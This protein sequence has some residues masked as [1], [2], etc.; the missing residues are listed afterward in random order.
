MTPRDALA[1]ALGSA[2][3]GEVVVRS[4]DVVGHIHVQKGVIVW[5]DLSSVPA[6]MEDV[7]RHVGVE[8]DADV[9]AATREE[10][11]TSRVHFM[12]VLVAW[13]IIHADRAKEAVRAFVSKRVEM[14]LALP[15]AAA[16]FLPKARPHAEPVR[17]SAGDTPLA[18]SPVRSRTPF[19]SSPTTTP[20]PLP[21]AEVSGLFEEAAR[22]EGA[23][24]VAVL[25][26]RTGKSILLSGAELNTAVAWSQV[27]L[28]AEPRAARAGGDR[29]DG[30]AL[31]HRPPDSGGPLARALRRPPASG[32]DR[33]PGALDDRP[34][35]VHGGSLPGP[36]M[37]VS[38]SI[39]RNEQEHG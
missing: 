25:D 4:G 37:T 5:A 23:V 24:S 35:C 19:P 13:K 1:E 2:A 33:R 17:F 15:D 14:A 27:S 7:V 39:E 31:L 16:L 10:C 20:R 11:R 6:S 22:L 26:C 12:D 32:D 34:D 18:R 8:L 30:R 36:R 9:I 38:G 3:G 29:V 28:L 21:V